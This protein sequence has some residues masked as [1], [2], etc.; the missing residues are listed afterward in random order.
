MDA[1]LPLED[2]LAWAEDELTAMEVTTGGFVNVYVPEGH[3]G[4]FTCGTDEVCDAARLPHP[5]FFDGDV[6]ITT[7]AETDGSTAPYEGE[8]I[9]DYYAAA[10]DGPV[11]LE[12][13]YDLMGHSGMHLMSVAYRGRNDMEIW[14]EGRVSIGVTDRV[15]VQWSELYPD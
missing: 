10:G 14:A 4:V 2:H 15:E 13:H 11:D 7:N 1:D 9:E 6:L 5:D 3:G 12:S 8:F